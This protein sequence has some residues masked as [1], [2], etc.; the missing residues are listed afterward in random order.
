MPMAMPRLNST[1]LGLVA[2]HTGNCYGKTRPGYFGV[3]FLWLVGGLP[4]ANMKLMTKT[5]L[6]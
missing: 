5:D 3:H 1:L 6:C 2:E 4:R